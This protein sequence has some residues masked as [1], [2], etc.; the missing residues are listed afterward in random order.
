MKPETSLATEDAQ[1]AFSAAGLLAACER[2]QTELDN[3]LR[4]I[5]DEQLRTNLNRAGWELGSA[6]L[7]LKYAQD[8]EKGMAANDNGG[9]KTVK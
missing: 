9:H 8:R 2:L 4:P 5:I 1:P 7:W 6:H 3:A